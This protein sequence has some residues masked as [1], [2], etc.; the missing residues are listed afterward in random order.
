MCF[1]CLDGY[2][3]AFALCVST[4]LMATTPPLPCVSTALMAKTPPLPFVST[5]FRHPG[6]R[7]VAFPGS[8]LVALLGGHPPP[9]SA[10]GLDL[11]LRPIRWESRPTAAI[12]MENPYCCNPYGEPLLQL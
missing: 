7:L 9:A 2:D 4:A 12:P 1:H 10:Q 5:A 11:G 8:G 6:H 3:T